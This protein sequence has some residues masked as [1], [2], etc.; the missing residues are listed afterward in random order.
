MKKCIMGV[1]CLPVLLAVSNGVYAANIGDVIGNIYTT[2]IVAYIDDMPIESYNI[3]GR[4]VIPIE[5]LRY[6]GFDVEWKE[7]ERELH[8]AISDMPSETPE[9]IP[10]RQTPGEPVG[11]IYYTD[12][13][14]S[15]NGIEDCIQTYNIGGITCAAIEDLGVTGALDDNI[16]RYSRYGMRYVYDND[17]RTIKLYTL[18][19][20]DL[21]ETKYGTALIKNI[22][23]NYATNS[24]IYLDD[25]EPNPIGRLSFEVPNNGK[26][27]NINDLP[28]EIGITANVEDSVYS[29]VSLSDEEIG[30]S[31]Y[32]ASNGGRHNDCVVLCL[33]LP[34][35]V[36]GSLVNDDNVNC[37]MQPSTYDDNYEDL[38]VG[39][40]FLNQ[41]TQRAFVYK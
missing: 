9:Y 41:Y 32:G 34:I 33:S 30:Y 7:N 27:I 28:P 17:S 26:Y 23:A 10:E 18:R 13:S 14:V 25:T 1:V 36:N 2:D 24:Y 11:T 4:T 39:M 31:R 15:I 6:Y 8:A 29:V 40:D 37:I 22:T 16:P 20:G 38:Y 35:K 5:E 12:I 21:L 19:T 3:G